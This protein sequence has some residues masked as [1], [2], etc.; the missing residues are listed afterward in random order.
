MSVAVGDDLEGLAG[1]EVARVD[2]R[3]EV[4]TCPQS[5]VKDGP[6][7]GDHPE[8]L[9]LPDIPEW[10]YDRTAGGQPAYQRPGKEALHVELGPGEPPEH[11]VGPG[12]VNPARLDVRP[13]KQSRH[14]GA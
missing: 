13:G 5:L 9:F 1:L 12:E 11:A 8:A 3:L 2:H 7:T 4:R 14:V 6:G 10:T